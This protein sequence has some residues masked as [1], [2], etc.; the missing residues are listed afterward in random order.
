MCNSTKVDFLDNL[1][2]RKV[3]KECG[4]YVP[5]KETATAQGPTGL[6]YICT[7]SKDLLS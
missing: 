4:M 1:H 6:K 7:G 3:V 2:L 5:S